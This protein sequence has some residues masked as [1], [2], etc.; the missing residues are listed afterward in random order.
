MVMSHHI[1]FK[2][3]LAGIKYAFCTQP[4]F[5]IHITIA[6][7]VILG[8]ALLQVPRLEWLILLFTISLVVVAEMINTSLESMT[9]LIEEK[10]HQNAKVAKDVSAGMVLI[11]AISSVL[12]GLII[13]L[14][15][16]IDLLSL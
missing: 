13:F 5:R 16:I 1:S 12:I 9:D 6:L 2:Y 10:Y 11:T 14:P 8:A 4:N 15:K 3:A 7:L